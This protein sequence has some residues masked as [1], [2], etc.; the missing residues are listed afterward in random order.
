MYFLQTISSSDLAGND[1]RVLVANAPH[2]YG[3]AVAG[4]D[5]YWTDWKLKSVVRADTT[6][7]EWRRLPEKTDGLM[8]MVAVQP[9]SRDEATS[10]AVND[11]CAHNN[12]GCSHLCLRQSRGF[13]CACP[14]GILLQNDG[15]TCLTGE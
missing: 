2:P 10:A 3:L 6:T 7:G 1:E 8:A 13:S 9:V 12:G 15:K 5:V 11:Q 4:G 14:T